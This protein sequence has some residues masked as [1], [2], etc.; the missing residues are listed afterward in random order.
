VSSHNYEELAALHAIAK[1]LAQPGEFRDQ[2]EQVLQ[3]MNQRVGMQ[4]G[5]ISLLDRETG[6]VWLDVAHGVDI[7]GMEVS[8]APGEG[9][10]GKVAQTGRPMAVANL[11]QEAHFMDRTGPR[12]FLNRSD[13]S[14]LCVP[15]VYDE[16]VV[17]VLSA[18]KAVRQVEDLDRELAMLSSIAELIAKSV[19]SR[20]LEEDNRRLRDMLGRSTITHSE[21]IGHSKVM[22]EVFGL[23]VQV[24]D[25]NATVLINGETGTGK[26]LVA[27]AIHN[28]SPRRKGPLIQV[29]CAAMPD[30]LIESELFGHEKGSFTG[31]FHHR[32][33][34]FEEAHGGTI[35][36]DEVGELSAAAQA[37]LLRV[38]QEKKFQPLGGSRVVSVDVR[39]IAATNRD[40]EQDVASGQFRADLYYRLNVFPLYLPPLRERGSDII[41]LADHF[42]MKYNNELG[43][44]IKTISN[45]VLEAFLSHPW[46]GNVRELENCIERAVLL[47][48]GSSIE[49]VHLP[50]SLQTRS[51]EGERK[52]SGKLNAMI[53]AQERGMIV[54][55]LKESRGNQSQAARIL[56][57]TKR[58]IQYKI[59]KLGIDPRRFKAKYASPSS[60]RD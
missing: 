53:E 47:A 50:P 32:R 33:G 2:L 11:G 20:A 35:F 7:Q 9:I 25:S 59:Q 51:R 13:L 52:E 44:S 38:I 26:E 40:L 27:L 42:I 15:I 34:R 14:F 41:L 16:R 19:H 3:A 36:L 4:R 24:A 55:A 1:T 43:K 37:K 30:T 22:Q 56:G 48:T 10:T 17:G 8:Y 18:D 28:R 60:P 5:M 45:A 58:I 46:P 39:I 23:I 12:R 29:N 21:I 49:T 6:E 54:D 57:T 31:A